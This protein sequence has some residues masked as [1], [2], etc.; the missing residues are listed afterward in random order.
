MR[1]VRGLALALIALLLAAQIVS[2]ESVSQR[3]FLASLSGQEEVPPVDTPAQGFALFE[4]DDAET[5]LDF[6]LIVGN[7]RNVTAAHIHCGAPGVNGPI[8]VFLFSGFAAFPNGVL[9]EG[10]IT[11]ADIIPIPS[12]PACP[13]GISSFAQLL[14]KMRTGDAY[15]NVHTIQHPGGEIRGQIR[16]VP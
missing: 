8:V 5:A 9:S 12:S 15:V 4:L 14:E 6:R 7:I 13:G 11:E 10:T 3:H 16:T 2:A 1:K